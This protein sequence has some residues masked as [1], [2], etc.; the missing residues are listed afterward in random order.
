MKI[1]PINVFSS[2]ITKISHN[3]YQNWQSKAR[4]THHAH[5]HGAGYTYKLPLI[6]FGNPGLPQGVP[7]VSVTAVAHKVNVTVD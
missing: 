6:N 1:P 3:S 2:H 5:T 7:L 4:N